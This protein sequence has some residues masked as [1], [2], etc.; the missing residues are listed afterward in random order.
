VTPERRAALGALEVRLGHRFADIG[1][2][3]R[4]L[5]HTSHAHEDLSGGTRHNEPL[6]FLG[7]SVLG[8]LVAALLHRLD[9]EGD[10]GTKTRARAY[11]VSA[12]TLV[13]HAEALG[14]PPLL[15]LGRGEE[16]SG[17]RRKANLWVDAYE[18][19]VAALYLDGG[20]EAARCFVEGQCRED[21]DAGRHL[22]PKDFKSRIQ[23][24]LQGRGEPTPEYEIEADGPSHRPVFRAH[25]VV[26]GR[27]LATGTGPSKKMAEQEA[28]RLALE[29]LEREATA[30]PRS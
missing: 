14:L 26:L 9:P 4:A 8:F 3:D 2:L 1:L 6:E 19:V 16:R 11:F 25:C 10:E 23:E 28:A 22:A 29:A 13:R 21:L 24:L 5:T 20:I 7:D 15:R 30:T 17:G 12:P 27:R 18:A